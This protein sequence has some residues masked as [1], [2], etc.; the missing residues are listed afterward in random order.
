MVVF[1]IT[2]IEAA[3]G[4]ETLVMTDETTRFITQKDYI[5]SPTRKKFVFCSIICSVL[6]VSA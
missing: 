1:G 3:I 5:Y 4:P 2:K 6:L